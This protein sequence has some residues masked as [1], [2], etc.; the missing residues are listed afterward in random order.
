MPCRGAA[1]CSALAPTLPS[2]RTVA[3]GGQ[4]MQLPAD[5]IEA[6]RTWARHDPDPE[7]RAELEALI[8]R[9]AREELAERMAG[10]LRF[11]TAGLRGVVGAG[12]NRMNRAVVIRASCGLADW[13]IERGLAQRGPLVI[14][15]DARLSSEALCRDAIAVFAAKGL[16]VRHVPEPCPTPAVAFAARACGA[17]AAVVV[18]AS[19]NPPEYNGYKVYGPD[20]VQ[21]VPPVD[22]EIAARIAAAPFADEVPRVDDPLAHPRVR[23]LEGLRERYL[24]ALDGCLAP[25]P[26]RPGLR[27]VYTAMHGVGAAYALAALERAGLG[28]I[29]P[30]RE[31]IEPDGRFPT[32]RFPNPEE[33]EA[34][35]LAH[36]LAE[37]TGADLVIANDP[38]ADRLAVS[39]PGRTGGFEPLTG[40]QIGALLGDHLLEHASCDRP[41]VVRSIVSSPLLDR[42]AAAHGARSVATLTGFKWIWHAA[43]ELEGRGEGT[44]VFGYEEAIGFSVW[45]QVR[46]K[47]GISAAAVLAQLA[48]RERRAGGSLRARLERLYRAHGVWVSVQHSV[49]R[50]GLE[51][52]REIEQAMA[53]LAERRPE[54]LGGAAVERVI[55]YREGAQARPSYLGRAELVELQLGESGRAL[56]RPS[57]TE[58]K[59]K[60]Y[61]DLCAP[62]DGEIARIE[63]EQRERARAVAL[64]LARFVGLEG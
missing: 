10:T 46:D 7:T 22:A 51:G 57:G 31:Q 21:I 8:A 39:V 59:L 17:V 2:A 18:T 25:R 23:P 62:A 40:N 61:V 36:A 26:E 53:Q 44:F 34:L 43:L 1:A 28:A 45:S 54:T 16:E 20:H 56:V 24:A 32:V 47:D 11:G 5:P 30:V 52:R 6:A 37:R 55:D 13:L 64:E 35:A 4:P 3:A 58:P 63:R 33:P 29:E 49:W 50:P 41:F 12:S 38:D 27:V 19:H 60:I 14:G 42:V 48:E 9:G 15:R